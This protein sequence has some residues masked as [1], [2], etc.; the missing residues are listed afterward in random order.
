[1]SHSNRRILLQYHGFFWA[2]DGRHIAF[3]EVEESHIPEYV[4]PGGGGP[5]AAAPVY[6][7]VF[8]LMLAVTVHKSKPD[9]L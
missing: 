6:S 1:V 4:S 5:V 3:T 9:A 7:A 8:Q 2:P